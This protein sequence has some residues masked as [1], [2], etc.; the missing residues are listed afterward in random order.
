MNGIPRFDGTRGPVDAVVRALQ[1]ESAC[2]ELERDDAAELECQWYLLCTNDAVGTAFVS[3]LGA[4]P[5]CLR[6]ANKHDL[7]VTPL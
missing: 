1:A 6:C 4:V 3:I 7:E 5:I 2:R